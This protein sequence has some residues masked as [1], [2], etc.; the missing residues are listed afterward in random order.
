LHSNLADVDKTIMFWTLAAALT[1]LA[2][3][4]VA[5]PLLRAPRD[6]SSSLD[7]DREIY[8]QRLKEI[9][10]ELAIG[11]LGKAESEA[12]RA[13]EGRKLLAISE[14]GG[15]DDIGR[16]GPP[17]RGFAL[18]AAGAV[19]VLAVTLYLFSGQP[20][21]PDM[22]VA[23]RDGADLSQQSI[24]EL[25]ARAEA[26]L[27]SNPGDLRG[28]LVVAPVYLRLGRAEDAVTAYR[29][30]LRIDPGNAVL[31]TALGEAIVASE[32]GIVVERARQLFAEAS[33][34]APDDHKARFYLAVALGQQGADAEAARA[35]RALIADAP[36]DAP[37]LDAARAR[38]AA[39]DH[40]LAAPR[41]EGGMAGPTRDD[42]AAASE[43]SDDERSEMIEGMVAGLAERLRGDPS[44]KSGWRRLIRSYAVL[45]RKE[46]ATAAIAEA[47]THFTDDRQFTAE[48][49]AIERNLASKDSA[50]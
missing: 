1:L 41:A 25:L 43:M 29:N 7:H 42:I 46:A 34:A 31:K 35:W 11:R 21:M 38:L 16:A 32:Q 30:A 33:Q 3:L 5:L 19:P 20:H 28:W 26:R 17:S 36:A 15:A 12:A 9:E 2:M 47:R 37:W 49:A 50:Q 24:S 22:A 8:K 27:A 48:L 23:S 44:D 45:G 40:G 39:I 6:V 13:E 18:L 10:T 14:Q 4:C